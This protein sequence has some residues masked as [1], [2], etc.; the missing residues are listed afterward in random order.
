MSDTS[1]SADPV[2]AARRRQNFS[3]ELAE[4]GWY[5]SI[6]LPSGE[7]LEG[8]LSL[9]HLKKRYA[10]FPLP[11]DLAGKTTLDIGAWDGWFSF[12]MERR[13]AAVTAVDCVEIENF[14]YARE[15]IGSSV[16]YRIL[17][18]Y[19]LS[20]N[21][22]GRFDYVLFLGVL[23]HLKHPLLALEIVCELT[24]DIAIV[25]SFVANDGVAGHH[26]DSDIP[27]MEFYETDELG[28]Q[29]D[30]WIGPSVECLLALCRAAGFARVEL[31]S[32][33]ES[34]ACV[35]CYRHWGA[36][37][38]PPAAEAPQLLE[39][40]HSRNY[41]INFNSRREEY[42]TCWFQS[43]EPDLKRGDVYP[44]AGGYGVR[45]MYLKPL[46]E[47]RWQVNF[48]LPPGLAAGWH[49]VRLRTANSAYG[50]PLRIAV[51]MPTQADHLHM[52]SVCDGV[53]WKPN[54][55]QLREYGF[56]SFWIEGL[57]ENCDRNNLRVLLGGARLRVDFIS[58]PDPNGFR[59]VN[60]RVPGATPA[61]EHVM[62]VSYGGA[63]CEPLAIQVA[64]V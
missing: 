18:M 53:T 41:G 59:Q 57:G 54:E 62:S 64:K 30:N 50:K 28:E 55:V 33:N 26:R 63:V 31:L 27:W 2:R 9:P 7:V 44:E 48:R 21:S 37:P 19:E 40:A 22:V 16:E 61:G 39:I 58:A 34:R 3:R 38:A 42:V 12:E 56:L 8:V 52:A 45:A 23:Y 46:G 5:H 49:D 6:E 32:L 25:E 29:L 35:A 36:P 17:D 60:V 1:A 11:Q 51:D 15:R 13:G 20:A 43:A 14:L 4:K 47:G 10:E 24:R